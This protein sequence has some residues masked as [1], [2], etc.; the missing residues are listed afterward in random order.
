MRMTGV[1]T[2]ALPVLHTG[3]LKIKQKHDEN[4]HLYCKRMWT[5]ARDAFEGHDRNQIAVQTQLIGFFVDGLFH[6]HLQLKVMRDN[7]ATFEETV[8]TE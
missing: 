1:T 5:I 3:E 6:D 8:R 4:V 2:I 7:P